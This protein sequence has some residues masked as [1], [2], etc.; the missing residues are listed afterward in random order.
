MDSTI[1]VALI[2][3]SKRVFALDDDLFL[4]FPLQF[5]LTFKPQDLSAI[6]APQTSADYAQAASF[7]INTNFIAR[8]TVASPDP[9][10]MLWDIFDEVLSRAIVA[11]GRNDPAAEARYTAAQEILYK[12]DPAGLRHE[13]QTY[14]EY[15]RYRD[16]VFAAQEAYG[17]QKQTA[18]QSGDPD[19]KRRWAEVDEPEL[20]LAID[21]ARLDWSNLGHREQV[22][23]AIADVM[24][25]AASN[26]S[27]RW[28]DWRAQFNRDTD[29]LHAGPTTFAPTGFSPADVTS[30]TSW[31]H[32]AMDAQEIDRLVADAPS[33]LHSAG[34]SDISRLEFDYRSVSVTRPW[35]NPSPLTSR[36]WRLPPGDE[37]LSYGRGSSTGRL[38][39]YVTALVLIRNV[40]ATTKSRP[41]E[42]TAMPLRFTLNP[43]LLTTR[44]L[45]SN[46]QL[47]ALQAV[48]AAAGPPPPAVNAA[49]FARVRAAT[50]T[51]ADRSVPGSPTRRDAMVAERTADPP[52]MRINPA[53]RFFPG[54]AL[55]MRRFGR[56]G[57]GAVAGDAVAVADP[58]PSP[59]PPPPQPV[60]ETPADDS[61]AVLAFICKRLPMTPNPFP[62]LVWS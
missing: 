4:S 18:E 29:L 52:G 12:T 17:M 45:T 32:A 11:I 27:A 42:G 13:S 53:A 3:K 43:Q 31:L 51:V 59:P 21:E 2:E 6:L 20:R 15:R 49:A 39:A 46:P 62:E 24:A 41:E 34:S 38:T 54:G 40:V 58:A 5:P 50:F 9:G 60:P 10:D 14:T 48:A 7:A 47:L 44:K 55:R 35:F 30:D 25:A 19:A 8:D 23:A 1:Q 28:A 37:A 22:E 36:I 26:P 56:D 16:V 33:E 57:I 61:I